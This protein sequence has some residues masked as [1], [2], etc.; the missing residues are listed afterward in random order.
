MTEDYRSKVEGD[1]EKSPNDGSLVNQSR[2]KS[3]PSVRPMNARIPRTMQAAAGRIA[4]T[5]ARNPM[6]GPREGDRRRRAGVTVRG[7]EDDPRSS[8]VYDLR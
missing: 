7:N 2:P 3:N 1:L 6:A 8:S 5:A 4:T